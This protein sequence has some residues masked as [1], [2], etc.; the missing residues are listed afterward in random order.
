[1][2]HGWEYAVVTQDSQ[3]D[4]IDVK[5]AGPDKVAHHDL[6]KGGFDRM[7]GA[8]G[9][10]EWELVSVTASWQAESHYVT[11]FYFKRPHDGHRSGAD[12]LVGL[13]RDAS[14]SAAMETGSTA[15]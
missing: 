9:G 8:L 3:H 13:V 7:L 4:K 15:A 1:M 5:F 11:Q 14:W 12:E 10:K 6:H 2:A